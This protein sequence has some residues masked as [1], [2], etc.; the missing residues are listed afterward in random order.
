MVGN[1]ILVIVHLP[2]FPKSVIINYC[3]NHQ[4]Q[5]HS[6]H[7]FFQK[8]CTYLQFEMN[9]NFLPKIA[10]LTLVLYE[11][12]KCYS[13][14]FILCG[15]VKVKLISIFQTYMS[16]CRTKKYILPLK[17]SITFILFERI[18]GSLNSR[19]SNHEICQLKFSLNSIIYLPSLSLLSTLYPVVR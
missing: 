16:V 14:I 2:I 9:N 15:H 13:T 12:R 3:K 10:F 5:F 11:R 19:Y 4:E 8:I 18:E 7:Q 17:L 1:L 6:L